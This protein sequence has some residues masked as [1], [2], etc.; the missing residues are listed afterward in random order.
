MTTNPRV[1]TELV[2]NCK[3]IT[4][5]LYPLNSVKGA[6]HKETSFEVTLPDTGIKFLF[7]IVEDKDGRQVERSYNFKDGFK[8]QVEEKKT[9]PS[10]GWDS[11][12]SHLRWFE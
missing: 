1:A 4:V 8:L 2:M 7:T 10:D 12:Y 5:A 6:R 11:L 3:K 9:S